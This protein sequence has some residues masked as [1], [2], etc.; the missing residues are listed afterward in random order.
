MGEIITPLNQSEARTTPYVLLYIHIILLHLLYKPWVYPFDLNRI[1]SAEF[2]PQ[3]SFLPVFYSSSIFQ[4]ISLSLVQ[5]PFIF[6]SSSFSLSRFFYSKQ[7]C[8]IL[9]FFGIQKS[10]SLFLNPNSIGLGRGGGQIQHAAQN[11]VLTQ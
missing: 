2:Y 3:F 11:S 7:N 10:L 6:L 9:H 4:I 8:R 5:S 1:A